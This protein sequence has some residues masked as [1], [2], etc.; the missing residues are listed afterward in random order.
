MAFSLEC[1]LIN[2]IIH[3]ADTQKPP[4]HYSV[5]YRCEMF[6]VSL[7]QHK[8]VNDRGWS[9]GNLSNILIEHNFLLKTY[10]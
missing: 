6:S 4:N 8:T 5:G 9:T 10:E 7:Y 1:P 2:L 3:Q